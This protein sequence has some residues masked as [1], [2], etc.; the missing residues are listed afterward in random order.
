MEAVVN[1]GPTNAEPEQAGP[2]RVYR[3][4]ARVG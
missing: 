1:V 4:K 2:N 3:L